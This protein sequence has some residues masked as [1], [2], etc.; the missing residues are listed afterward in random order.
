MTTDP[1]STDSASNKGGYGTPAPEDEVPDSREAGRNTASSLR[2]DQQANGAPSG[3]TELA[4]E[5]L[6]VDSSLR[7]DEEN[8]SDPLLEPLDPSDGNLKTRGV[9]EEDLK[10]SRKVEPPD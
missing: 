8:S 6:G 3:D 10:E 4:P 1:P 7:Q 5:S 2:E 9:S